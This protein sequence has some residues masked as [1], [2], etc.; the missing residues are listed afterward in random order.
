MSSEASM[1]PTPPG[2]DQ[3]ADDRGPSLGL[4]RLVMA[5]YWLFGAW[6][7]VVGVATLVDLDGRPAGPALVALLA[8][9]L[10]LVAAVGITHNGRRMRIVGW[11][12]V[13]IETAGPVIVGLVGL[14][15]PR[16]STV[17]SPWAAF[18]ADYWYL[19]LVIAVVGLVWLWRSNP[20]R[21]VELAE[22]VER[23]GRA[24]RV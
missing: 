6:T 22:Q 23:P 7:T 4:G 3:V 24:H 8:G 20:R 14:G 1:G 18:G 16:Q 13:I 12:A 9:L 19:P 2:H 15:V 10:Y 5:A 21:I 17:R 11:T